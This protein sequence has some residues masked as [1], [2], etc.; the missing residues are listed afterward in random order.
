M[1]SE[2]DKLERYV[3]RLAKVLFLLGILLLPYIIM[4]RMPAYETLSELPEFLKDC[5]IIYYIG[6][7]FGGSL[8]SMIL[9]PLGYVIPACFYLARHYQLTAQSD[10]HFGFVAFILLFFAGI[11]YMVFTTPFNIV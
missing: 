11:F 6:V 8:L 1:N 2:T 10:Q 7:G 5:L 9:Y 4:S 3:V